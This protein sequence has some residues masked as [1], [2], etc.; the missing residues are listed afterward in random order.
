[1][2][3]GGG[4]G[5]RCENTCVHV[6]GKIAYYMQIRIVNKINGIA[7]PGQINS[8]SPLN[9]NRYMFIDSNSFTRNL[10]RLTWS[11]SHM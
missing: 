3:V 11:F 1:M 10:L 9:V 2:C 8:Q 4:G 5:G 7:Y 6:H